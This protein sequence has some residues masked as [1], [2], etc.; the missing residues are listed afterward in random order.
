MRRPGEV[1]GLPNIDPAKAAAGL[2]FHHELDRAI[3]ANAESKEY[4]P[5]Q[6]HPI[7]G[8]DQ[9]TKQSARLRAGRLVPFNELNGADESGDGTVPRPSA[10]PLGPSPRTTWHL[11]VRLY[12]FRE[13]TARCKTFRKSL[14]RYRTCCWSQNLRR[15]VQ[16]PKRFRWE[17]TMPMWWGTRQNP[18]RCRNDDPWSITDRGRGSDRQADIQTQP[19]ATV[20]RTHFGGTLAC[21]HVSGRTRGRRA[22][23]HLRR[24]LGIALIL[25]AGLGR[26]PPPPRL[27][28]PTFLCSGPPPSYHREYIT[29]SAASNA[30]PSIKIKVVTI[31]RFLQMLSD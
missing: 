10:I 4:K 23:A 15:I 8:T 5:Y 22:K 6:V 13:S 19:C 26:R 21:W 28:T 20:E 30:P 1:S 25:F 9:P 31:V 27:P 17:W 14:L 2:A 3:R 29:A 12:S 18:L 11:D 7:I 16:H 24:V